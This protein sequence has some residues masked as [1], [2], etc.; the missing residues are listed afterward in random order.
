MWIFFDVLLFSGSYLGCDPKLSQLLSPLKGHSRAG[1]K[2]LPKRRW[3]GHGS[4]C[5]GSQ[6]CGSYFWIKD[7]KPHHC[8]AHLVCRPRQGTDL[9]IF[10]I[11]SQSFQNLG[12]EATILC[13]WACVYPATVLTWELASKQ[14]LLYEKYYHLLVHLQVM[15]WFTWWRYLLDRKD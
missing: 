15:Y 12:R 1:P 2:E 3:K 13:K 8:R 10:Q 6:F 11:F 4:A 9:P 14:L 7:A 5:L